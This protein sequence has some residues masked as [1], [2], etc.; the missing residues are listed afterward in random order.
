[1]LC[2][3]FGYFF[4]MQFDEGYNASLDAERLDLSV[5]KTPNPK[6]GGGMLGCIIVDPTLDGN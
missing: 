1:M 3:E 2:H 6:K 4:L 5:G